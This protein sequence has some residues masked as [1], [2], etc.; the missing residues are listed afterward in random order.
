VSN[1]HTLIVTADSQ[2]R[3]DTDLF[4]YDIRCPG[5]SD[6][7][8]MWVECDIPTCNAENAGKDNLTVHG[9]RHQR[10]ASTWSVPTDTCYLLIADEMPDA[11]AFLV[12]RDH[13][14]AG[15]YQV[16]HDFDEGRIADLHLA[17]VTQ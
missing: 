15:E 8:R 6:A 2:D 5:V 4:A 14:A 7:C 12:T 11:A 10:I 1:V 3:A 17:A 13:L 9:K 16:G